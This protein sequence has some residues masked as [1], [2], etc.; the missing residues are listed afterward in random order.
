M[1]RPS[2]AAAPQGNAAKQLGNSGNALTARS[3]EQQR[4]RASGLTL[5]T[6]ALLI[7]SCSSTSLPA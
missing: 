6:A 5:V 1:P 3:F 2:P 4:Y 7:L